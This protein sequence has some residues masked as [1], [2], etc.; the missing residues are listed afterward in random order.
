MA[1]ITA[2]KNAL[3]AKYAETTVLLANEEDARVAAF[4]DKKKAEADVVVMKRD[5]EGYELNVAKIEQEKAVK[6]HN[7]RVLNDEI[8]HQD[9]IINKLTKEKKLAVENAEYL[10]Q[11]EE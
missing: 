4:N 9:E 1:H 7:I 2:E 8:A 3:E 11:Y 10:R 6:D 5:Y